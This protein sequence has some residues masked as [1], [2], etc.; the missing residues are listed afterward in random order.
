[1]ALANGHAKNDM[2]GFKPVD[3]EEQGGKSFILPKNL[4]K[5]ILNP[6]AVPDELKNQLVPDE[7]GNPYID[8]PLFRY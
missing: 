3:T 1:M 4:A 7:D 8:R 6:V 2:D 5:T